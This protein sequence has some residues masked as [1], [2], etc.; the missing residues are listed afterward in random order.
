MDE[1][2]GD[3]NPGH[4][5]IRADAIHRRDRSEVV[6]EPMVWGLFSL[7]GLL[8]AF[9]MPVAIVALSLA[10]PLGVWSPERV[11]FDAYAARYADPLFRLF[12]FALIG[13]GLFHGMHRLRHI[14]LDAGA[15]RADP[16]LILVLYGIAT[17][18][19][20]AAL[21]YTFLADWLGLRL[22]FL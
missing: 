21:W 19:S 10:V 1:P 17:L 5:A 2:Q 16:L 11:G 4:E 8:T 12:L 13:G 18:G 15:K 3:W 9:L 6:L 20:L 22:P 7:G 14:L